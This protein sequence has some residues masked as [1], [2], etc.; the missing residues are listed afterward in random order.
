MACFRLLG[1]TDR[2]TAF[3]P[4]RL[5]FFIQVAQGQGPFT[6]TP[7][8]TAGPGLTGATEAKLYLAGLP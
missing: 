3:S 1:P 6:D 8:D 2:G 4:I 7:F 5:G